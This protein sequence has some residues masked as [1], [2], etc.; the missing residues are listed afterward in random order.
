MLAPHGAFGSA[1]PVSQ[2]GVSRR[3]KSSLGLLQ[4]PDLRRT[5]PYPPTLPLKRLEMHFAAPLSKNIRFFAD[6]L[7]IENSSKIRL[8]KN[9]PKVSKVGPLIAQTSILESLLG[10]VLA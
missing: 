7:P 5:P 4:T 10:S 6:F 8:L 9:S 2:S 3:V 1:A